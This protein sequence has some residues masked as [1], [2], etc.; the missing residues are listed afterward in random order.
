M[1]L[2]KNPQIIMKKL[3]LIP[4][5]LVYISFLSAAPSSTT[6]FIK[7]D[8]FGYLPSSKKVAVISDPQVGYNSAESFTPGTGT[9]QYQVRRWDN[10]AIVYSGTISAWNGG[11]T[12]TQSGDRGWYFDFTSVSAAGSY[13]VFDVSNNV[14]SYRFEINDNVYEEVLKQAIRSFFYQRINFAKQSPYTNTKW[15]D[16]A[17]LEGVG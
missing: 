12:H 16:G 4:L 8:Q 1:F 11:Q 14:G 15:A 2:V 7:V 9:N 3:H 6:H 17:C 13:Y 10:D 5:F